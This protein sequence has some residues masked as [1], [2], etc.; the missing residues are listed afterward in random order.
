MA[1]IEDITC[2]S[3]IQKAKDSDAFSLSLGL[4]FFLIFPVF[5]GMVMK[6]EI[7]HTGLPQFPFSTYLCVPHILQ[8]P[9]T[10][11]SVVSTRRA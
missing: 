2:V 10:S 11:V 7:A 1:T 3:A 9:I 4:H 5:I 8:I 6:C